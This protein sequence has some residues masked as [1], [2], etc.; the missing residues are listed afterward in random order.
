MGGWIRSEAFW[1]DVSSQALG[2][3]VVGFVGLVT[4]AAL[5]FVD[6]KAVGQGAFIVL[7]ILVL[8]IA[9]GA[10]AVL[11]GQLLNPIRPWLARHYWWRLLIESLII[12]LPLGGAMLGAIWLGR[13]LVLWTMTW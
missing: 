8:L 6:F 10:W 3:L 11:I 12:L 4:A 7:V 2:G 13:A 1:R 5:G 9:L